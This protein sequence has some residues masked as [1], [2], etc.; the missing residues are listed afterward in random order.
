MYR[1]LHKYSENKNKISMFMCEFLKGFLS[2]A[3][4]WLMQI[5]HIFEF[6]S[7]SWL[8]GPNSKMCRICIRQ[9]DAIERKRFSVPPIVTQ[10]SINSLETIK[11]IV[12]R[13]IRA[14]TEF[15]K[16]WI[17][18]VHQKISYWTLP[19]YFI[20]GPHPP[21]FNALFSMTITAI[22]ALFH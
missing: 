10:I 14:S 11:I 12:G 16:K 15:Y 13:R 5:L 22:F 19:C 17:W 9:H 6:C 3:S 20:Q 18:N 2:M 8:A 4:H 21:F 7:A 1:F